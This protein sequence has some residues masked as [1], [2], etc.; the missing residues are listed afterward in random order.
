MDNF[1]DLHIFHE[2]VY[3]INHNHNNDN[4]LDDFLFYLMNNYLLKFASNQT[5]TVKEDAA[6]FD[7]AE[8]K[9][10]KAQKFL[11]DNDLN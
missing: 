11:D 4:H 7:L 5:P 2:Y 10:A 9:K 6:V 8:A 1:R 3:L